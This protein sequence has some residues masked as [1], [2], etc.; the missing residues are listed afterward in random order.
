MI[1]DIRPLHELD[2]FEPTRSDLAD[3]NERLLGAVNLYRSD[4]LDVRR[5]L[6]VALAI[7]AAQAPLVDAARN[8]VTAEA[9]S[10]ASGE[11]APGLRNREVSRRRTMLENAAFDF[12][13]ANPVTA[14]ASPDETWRDES[15]GAA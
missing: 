14:K 12:V 15:R 1:D 5:R 8:L 9:P 13:R 3:E 6:D 7:L 11:E 10:W 2:T 4:A